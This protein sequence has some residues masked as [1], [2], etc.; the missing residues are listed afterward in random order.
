MVGQGDPQ[1]LEDL[2]VFIGLAMLAG[3]GLPRGGWLRFCRADMIVPASFID[4]GDLGVVG[5]VDDLADLVLVDLGQT[6]GQ[7]ASPGRVRVAPGL[8]DL[9]SRLVAVVEQ[10]R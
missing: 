7:G 4:P 1:L 2:A 3:A 5:G 9:L 6:I 8:E 10:I